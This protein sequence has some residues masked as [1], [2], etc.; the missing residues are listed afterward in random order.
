MLDELY[1]LFIEIDPHF[2][3]VAEYFGVFRRNKAKTIHVLTV[4]KTFTNEKITKFMIYLTLICL[5]L[6]NLENKSATFFILFIF[7][8]RFDALPKIFNRVNLFHRAIDRVSK[9]VSIIT[10][11]AFY[12]L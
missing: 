12:P 9:I 10:I 3:T 7:P 8:L 11:F 4:L 5:R 1:L 6:R 2:D